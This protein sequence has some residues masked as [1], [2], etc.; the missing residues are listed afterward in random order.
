MPANSRP[1]LV[2]K[3]SKVAG[4]PNKAA[5][6]LERQ[7]R[8]GWAGGAGEGDNRKTVHLV[9]WMNTGKKRMGTHNKR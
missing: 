2:L 6:K 8:K 9:K 4:D 3:I 1:S 5:K 7:G